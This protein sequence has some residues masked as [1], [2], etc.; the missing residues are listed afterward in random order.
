[1]E[2]TRSFDDDKRRQIYAQPHFPYRRRRHRIRP[3]WGVGEIAHVLHPVPE[4]SAQH[5][6][7]VSDG[8]KQR[9]SYGRPSTRPADMIYP[10]AKAKAQLVLMAMEVTRMHGTPFKLGTF[11]KS[12][13]PPFAA[14]VLGN[15]DIIELSARARRLS[16]FAAPRHLSATGSISCSAGELGRE[17]RRAAGDRGLPRQGGRETRRRARHQPDRAAAGRPPGQD[18]LR[19]AELPGAR[20]RD[21]PRRHVAD[22]RPEIHRREIDHRAVSVPQGAELPRRRQRRHR[23]PERRE[24]GRLGGRDRLRHLQARQAHQGRARARSRRRLDDHERRLRPRPADPHRPAG[25]CARTG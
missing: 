21:D 10:Y 22:G 6:R 14:I 15:N 25:R 13:E 17:L 24:E 2:G 19:R 9:S 18:V 11:A 3:R 12:G 16:R 20:R 5:S 23:D 1:M 7:P 4:R 8:R